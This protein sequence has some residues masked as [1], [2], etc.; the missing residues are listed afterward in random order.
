[1]AA[2]EPGLAGE[3][4]IVVSKSRDPAR[5]MKKGGLRIEKLSAVGQ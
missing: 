1:M 2:K 3:C 4:S 5:E